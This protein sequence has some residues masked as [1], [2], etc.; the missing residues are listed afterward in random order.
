MIFSRK[1]LKFY[2]VSLLRNFKDDSFC[3]AKVITVS[4]F[5]TWILGAEAVMDL[6]KVNS[7]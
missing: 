1:V 4:L 5:D 2:V 7:D 6:N 3:V